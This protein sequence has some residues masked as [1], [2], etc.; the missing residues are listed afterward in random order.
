MSLPRPRS[1]AS[2]NPLAAPRSEP[3]GV[4]ELIRLPGVGRRAAER[5]VS[6]REAHGPF[7]SEWDL[8]RVEGF[9]DHRVHQI[10][11]RIRTPRAT[12][13]AVR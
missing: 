7:D 9:D 4:E 1:P 8:M 11:A 10:K 13:G 2:A 6:Y 12:N 3:R 5:I